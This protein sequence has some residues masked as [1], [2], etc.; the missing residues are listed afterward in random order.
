MLLL[1]PLHLLG[2]D[3]A[4]DHTPE[5]NSIMK[6]P[7]VPLWRNIHNL[8]I[9]AALSICEKRR[10]T[11]NYNAATIILGVATNSMLHCTHPQRTEVGG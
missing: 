11:G 9:Q 7:F 6:T 3:K 4:L 2:A 8:S 5:M 10:T 1:L